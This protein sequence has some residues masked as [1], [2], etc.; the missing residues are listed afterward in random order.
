MQQ[1]EPTQDKEIRLLDFPPAE[2]VLVDRG[3][4]VVV[5][6]VADNSY[7]GRQVAALA[8]STF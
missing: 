4:E 3:A 8:I 2:A 6:A 7:S 1:V 5:A